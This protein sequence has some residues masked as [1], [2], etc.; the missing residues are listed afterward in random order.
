MNSTKP[1]GFVVAVGADMLIDQVD[2]QDQP[3][4]KI[5]RRYVFSAKVGFR[6]AHVF[7][8]N[9]VGGLLLQKI[10]E[11]RPRHPGYWGSS[12]AA[13]L[14]SGENYAAAARRRAEEELGIATPD[15]LLVGKTVM[16]DEGCTKFISLFTT[17]SDGPF[18]F[19]RTHIESLDF[20][21]LHRIRDMLLTGER[22]FT[23]TF[24]HLFDFYGRTAPDAHA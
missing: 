19:D 14:F 17:V 13:Y 1:G 6:V 18:N 20:L 11:R 16:N 9:Q 7:V 23:P 15:L 5:Q 3:I 4:G 12:V 22:K 8:F 2:S 24:V 10:A 21:S